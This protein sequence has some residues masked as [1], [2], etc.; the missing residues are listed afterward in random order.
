[1]P[2]KI[3]I[4]RSAVGGNQG[5]GKLDSAELAYESGRSI[6]YIGR[7]QQGE[8][9]TQIVEPIG[10]S[11]AFV[12]LTQA[13]DIEGIKTFKSNTGGG[14]G[15]TIGTN[16]KLDCQAN[17]VAE[18]PSLLMTGADPNKVIDENTEQV[19]GA[20]YVNKNFITKSIEN[21]VITSVKVF[22]KAPQIQTALANPP[23]A[24][25]FAVWGY[26]SG[27]IAAS[28]ASLKLNDES[29]VPDST[30]AEARNVDV[31]SLNIINLKHPRTP[32]TEGGELITTHNTDAATRAYVDGADTAPRLTDQNMHGNRIINVKVDGNN[33]VVNK[34]Y[35]DNR[36]KGLRVF[37]SCDL[38]TAEPIDN[39]N[40]ENSD[41]PTRIVD[42]VARRIDGV[43]IKVGDIILFKDQTDKDADDGFSIVNGIY[44]VP[45]DEGGLPKPLERIARLK[46]GEDASL[47]F[48]FIDRGDSNADHGFVCTNNEGEAKVGT[49]ALSFNKFSDAQ[50]GTPITAGDGISIS[51]GVVA[52]K[53]Q[54]PLTFTGA[55]S[56]VVG[57]S[58]TL[59]SQFLTGT[60]AGPKDVPPKVDGPNLTFMNDYSNLT[61]DL[62]EYTT[63]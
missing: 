18:N 47:V 55:S 32:D 37:P 19:V 51:S 33:S 46:D 2:N 60:A 53:I 42:G 52:T 43:E 41:P 54:P 14:S 34:E 28:K 1:M 39:W 36:I 25:D 61:I 13:Q 30:I 3:R 31:N 20:G 6:L 10:G 62:G 29:L 44:I 35:V 23:D 56:D 7:D 63:S 40:N 48:T 58:P 21:E 24:K 50:G 49:N 57:I 4:K 12:A 8:P 59:L 5:P 26:V 16:A 27:Q 22:T 45:E 11:G 9:P 15:I 17:A 38:A